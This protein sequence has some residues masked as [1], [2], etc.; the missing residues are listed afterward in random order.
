MRKS[1][2]TPVPGVRSERYPAQQFRITDP[3]AQRLFERIRE[4]VYLEKRG[5]PSQVKGDGFRVRSRRSSGVQI[6][7]LA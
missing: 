6:S 4:I 7:S 2:W 3:G 1:G 5:L